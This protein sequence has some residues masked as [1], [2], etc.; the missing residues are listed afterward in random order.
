VVAQALLLLA[1]IAVPRIGPLWPEPVRLAG[2]IAGALVASAGVALLVAGAVALG[3]NLT[4]LP[5]PKDA[6]TLVERGPYRVVRHPIYGG[7]GLLTLG[8][9]IATGHLGRLAVAIAVMVFLAA[10]AGREERWLRARFTG[11]PAYAR[12]VRRLV[13]WVY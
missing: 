13:P 8:V 10:K 11:Y 6:A 3:R 2:L 1:Y 4:P 9:A 5:H 7:V 12:R